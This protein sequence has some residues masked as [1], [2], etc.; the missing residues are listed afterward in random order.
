MFQAASSPKFHVPRRRWAVS[1]STFFITDD[2]NTILHDKWHG[3]DCLYLRLLLYFVLIIQVLFF[4]WFAWVEWQVA[5]HNDQI[6]LLLPMRR[7][8]IKILAFLDMGI[9]FGLL[10]SRTA[11]SF[12]ECQSKVLTSRSQKMPSFFIWLPFIQYLSVL[13]HFLAFDKCRHAYGHV[14]FFDPF[15]CG[16]LLF[17]RQ[18]FVCK[19]ESSIVVAAAAV[20]LSLATVQCDILKPNSPRN[21]TRWRVAKACRTIY[22][23]C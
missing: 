13:G 4:L 12:F 22:L 7:S 5:R 11:S 16:Y 20:D 19:K 10:A 2:T 15:C 17:F 23:T 1:T 3:Y 21:S 6:L 8:L 18:K 9:Q 14:I